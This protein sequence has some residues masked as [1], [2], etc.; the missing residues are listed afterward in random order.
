VVAGKS[1]DDFVKERIFTPLGMHAVTSAGA[2]GT[3]SDAATPHT[4][5]D[6]RAIAVPRYNSDNVGPAAAIHAS[7]ADMAR[8]LRLQLGLGRFEGNRIYSEAAAR[9]M[10]SPLTTFPLDGDPAKPSP[11]HLRAYALGWFVSDFHGKLRAEHDGS[12]D[13]YFSKVILIPELKVGAAAL[14][15]SDTAVADALANRAIDALLGLPPRDRSGEAL[16]RK[17]AGES[18]KKAAWERALAARDK[19]SKPSLPLAQY[20]G[21]YGG[22]L[23]GD[24]AVAEEG[25]RL[26]LRFEPAPAFVADLEHW[27]YDTFRVKWRKLNPYVPD[28]WATFV[29]DRRGRPAELRV[30]CPNPDFDFTELEL[31]RR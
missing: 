26:V 14:A 1:W 10:W 12:I 8:W 15:N 3:G 2:I 9:A 4:V 30:D 31:K 24:V 17:R 21:R 22:D 16:A 28:G 20:A 18:A 29:L 13:G 6:G 7:A 19:T 23:Y 27:Q 5:R 25:G 11:T